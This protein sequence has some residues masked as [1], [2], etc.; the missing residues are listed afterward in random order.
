MIHGPCENANRAAPCMKDSLKIVIHDKEN[1]ALKCTPN[2][3]FKE[4][5]E[6]L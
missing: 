2:F 6:N 1:Q 3:V 5:L 4:V